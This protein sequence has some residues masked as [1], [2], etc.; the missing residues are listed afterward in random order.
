M[1]TSSSKFP[2]AVETIAM[3]VMLLENSNDTQHP[4]SEA[5]SDEYIACRH[6]YVMDATQTLLTKHAATKSCE[7]INISLDPGACTVCD[8]FM[9]TL[10]VKIATESAARMNECQTA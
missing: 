3:M 9:A 4:L 8:E 5:M 7:C 1:G 2:A 6:N 10:T